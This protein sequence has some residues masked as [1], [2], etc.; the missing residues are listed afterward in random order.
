MNRRLKVI[1]KVIRVSSLFDTNGPRLDINNPT[2][3][4]YNVIAFQVTGNL[5]YDNNAGL[6]YSDEFLEEKAKSFIHIAK[7]TNASLVLTPEGSIKASLI[8]EIISDNSQWPADGKLWCFCATG[9]P[10]DEYNTMCSRYDSD[11]TIRLYRSDENTCKKYINSLWYLFRISHNELCVIVQ[12]KM[13]SMIDELHTGEDL[14]M[15]I[16]NTLYL[17]DLGI[18]NNSS[19][20]FTSLICSDAIG[21]SITPLLS[22]ASS[23]TLLLFNPQFNPKPRASSF[24]TFRTTFFGDQNIN[25]PKMIVLNWGDKSSINNTNICINDGT[26]SSIITSSNRS[27]FHTKELNKN[28]KINRMKGLYLFYDDD[29]H[30]DFWKLHNDE[31]VLQFMLKNLES[32]GNNSHLFSPYSVLSDNVYYFN[33]DRHEWIE[34]IIANCDH[35][36]EDKLTQ[37]TK[38]QLPFC[39]RKNEANCCIADGCNLIYC[40]FFFALCFGDSKKDQINMN[41]EVGNKITN[42]L[43]SDSISRQSKSIFLYEKLVELLDNNVFPES[44]KALYY[45]NNLFSIDPNAAETGSNQIYN[46]CPIAGYSHQRAIVSILDSSVISEIESVYCTLFDVT[47]EEYK[48]QIIIYCRDQKTGSFVPY[49]A[50]HMQNSFKDPKLTIHP[51]SIK[52]MR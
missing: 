20:L 15:T 49:S 51:A 12:L 10:N 32:Y 34:H 43:D 35:S 11:M 16:G 33:Y 48:N 46:L 27:V 22:I 50:P 41:R 13:A 29:R 26:G 1:S 8:D 37:S 44:L 9:I 40:D 25:D 24:Q 45:D 52:S 6:Q 31:I 5:S 42:A 39:C 17:F 36:F 21:Q 4:N 7:E 18:G 30:I 23:S 28:R 3:A 38:H 2:L 19:Q 47:H 14:G